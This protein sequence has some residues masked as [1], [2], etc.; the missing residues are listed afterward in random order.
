MEQRFS[1]EIKH[2]CKLEA[3]RSPLAVTA[4]EMV[5]FGTTGDQN[6]LQMRRGPSDIYSKPYRFLTNATNVKGRRCFSFKVNPRG[7]KKEK[8]G[9]HYC[10]T[11]GPSC[12]DAGPSCPC[13]AA[14]RQ[15][16]VFH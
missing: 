13:Q 1:P 10:A 2:S 11:Y 4:A 5:I 9:G 3:E 7:N 15:V 12:R 6:K 14:I 8:K 16:T